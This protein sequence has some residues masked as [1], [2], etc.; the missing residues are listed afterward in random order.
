MHNFVKCLLDMPNNFIKI[1]LYLT[2]TEQKK[3]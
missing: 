1:D 2:D 3:S